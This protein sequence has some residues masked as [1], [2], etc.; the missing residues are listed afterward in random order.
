MMIKVMTIV[1]TRPELIKLCRVISEL[2]NHTKHILVHSGQNYDYELNEIFFQQLDIRRPDYFLNAVDETLAK[3]L[4]RDIKGA[5]NQLPDDKFGIII[6]NRAKL[7]IA[8][9]A[10]E[11][12]M[13]G[14]QYDNII[15]FVVNPFNDFWTCYRTHYRELL[16]DLFEGFQSRNPF[17]QS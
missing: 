17:L 13:N 10:I 14:R 16:F 4:R 11:R 6:I 12:R 2:D 7:T 1:G 5:K 3:T 15:A 9:Q 8:K